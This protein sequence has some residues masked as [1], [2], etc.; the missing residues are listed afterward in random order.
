[1]L[2][3]C[4]HFHSN[5]ASTL[6]NHLPTLFA[7][8][9]FKNWNPRDSSSVVYVP[10]KRNRCSP[11]GYSTCRYLIIYLVQV[12]YRPQSSFHNVLDLDWHKTLYLWW[13]RIRSKLQMFTKQNTHVCNKGGESYTWVKWR[14]G[15]EPAQPNLVN[16]TKQ[17]QYEPTLL[18]FVMVFES[19]LAHYIF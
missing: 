1:M 10:N 2:L 7:G 17:L 12:L 5:Y 6:I 18:L 3:L 13:S 15:T 11:K 9:N 19:C 14:N 8:T 16:N 4:I